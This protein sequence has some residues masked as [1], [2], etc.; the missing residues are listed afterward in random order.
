MGER[1]LNSLMNLDNFGPAVY[2]DEPVRL[3]GCQSEVAFADIVMECGALII[4]A[5]F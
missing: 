2:D 1:L 4:N 3:R 5:G